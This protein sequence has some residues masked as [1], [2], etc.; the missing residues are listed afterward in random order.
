MVDRDDG[1]IPAIDLSA[2]H[3][4]GDASQADRVIGRAM[5]RIAASGPPLAHTGV[6]A[7]VPVLVLAEVARWWSPGLA[8]A[9]LVTIFAGLTVA[10]TPPADADRPADEGVETRLLDWAQSG[11]VPTNG[12]LLAAFR[13]FER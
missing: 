9:A 2:L 1:D 3:A 6:P 13:G 5:A 12:D 7:P 4:Q 11:H 10:I 8:A